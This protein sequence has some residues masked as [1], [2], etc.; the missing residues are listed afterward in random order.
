[1]SKAQLSG[2]VRRLA[3]GSMHGG[4]YWTEQLVRKKALES[5]IETHLIPLTDFQPSIPYKSSPVLPAD[6][7]LDLHSSY[8]IVSSC[9]LHDGQGP[10]QSFKEQ[11][12]GLSLN[13]NCAPVAADCNS[14]R[15]G[16]SACVVGTSA[17]SRNALA[18]GATV[19]VEGRHVLGKEVVRVWMWIGCRLVFVK[20]RGGFVDCV[21]ILL[22]E[23]AFVLRMLYL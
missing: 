12:A 8:A 20:A 18:G 2:P 16:V 4:S 7:N 17:A 21:C 5:R 6:I 15:D 13:L 9:H 22:N 10:T 19:V 1:L 3:I 14:G 23:L 11:A